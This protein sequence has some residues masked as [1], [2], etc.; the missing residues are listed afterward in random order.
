MKLLQIV[1]PLLAFALTITACK[2]PPPPPPKTSDPD[3]ALQL[4]GPATFDYWRHS[5]LHPSN[6]QKVT[7]RAK[8]SD[9]AGIRSA[10]LL[11]FEF[12]LFPGLMGVPSKL[13]RTGG[14]WASVK[15]WQYS[16]LV[17]TAWLQFDW[18]RGFPAHTNVEYIFRVVNSQGRVTDRLAMFDAGDSPWPQDKILLYSTSRDPMQRT[19]NLCFFPD[20][21]FGQNW[22]QFLTDTERLIFDGYHTNNMVRPHKDRWAF[23]YTRHEIDGAALA[24]SLGEPKDYPD[25]LTTNRIEGIDAFGLLHRQPYSDLALMTGN[26][27]FLA[28]SLFTSESYNHGTAV[29]ET[30]HA[31]FRLSDEYEQCACFSGSTGSNV[32]SSLPDCQ[33]FSRQH[34][35]PDGDCRAIET[36]LGETR[37][38]PETQTFFPTSEEC[39]AFN[40][41]NQL[42]TDSCVTFID[43]DGSESYWAFLGTCIMHD[44]GD[45]QV[46]HFQRVCRIRVQ[47]YYDRLDATGPLAG[48]SA[49]LAQPILP[50]E[51]RENIFG[52]QKVVA[53]ALEQTPTGTTVQVSKV[54]LGIPTKNIAPV[55]DLELE[56]EDGQGNRRHILPLENPGK[57]LVEGDQGA[58]SMQVAGATRRYFNIPYDDSCVHAVCRNLE[59]LRTRP[60]DVLTANRSKL[61]FNLGEDIR[62]AHAEYERRQ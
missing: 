24:G 23:Y 56:F 6:R 5:P 61:V 49:S 60:R 39:T 15:S 27:Y 2:T 58:R 29:H 28:N 3:P 25:F 16:S 1:P 19:I 14:T 51:K 62:R 36:A 20:T 4:N 34:G 59:H 45:D 44:D 21:D 43:L 22:T 46:R 47:E 26:I 38:T 50:G 33:Q 31:V 12:E 35:I 7:F 41:A 55:T 30:S 40:L 8:V 13:R 18:E 42:P 53:M 9:P 10:E 57:L 17:D 52:Y 37:Y 48:N 32:F 11:V 54:K